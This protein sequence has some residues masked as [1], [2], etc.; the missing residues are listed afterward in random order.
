MY[1]RAVLEH[2]TDPDAVFAEIVRLLT[3]GGHYIGLTAIRWD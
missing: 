1:S 2:V 3:F